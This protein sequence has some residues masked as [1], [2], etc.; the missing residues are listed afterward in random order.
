[1]D[2]WMDR[3]QEEEAYDGWMARWKGIIVVT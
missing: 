3:R 1:M 2:G